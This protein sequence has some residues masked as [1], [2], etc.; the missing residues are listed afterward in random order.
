MLLRMRDSGQLHLLGDMLLYAMLSWRIPLQEIIFVS[1]LGFG[2]IVEEVCI[3][4]NDLD[5]TGSAD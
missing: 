1:F 2:S 3:I 4:S 5:W